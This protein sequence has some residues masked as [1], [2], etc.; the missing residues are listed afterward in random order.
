MYTN[1][2]TITI[3]P[4]YKVILSKPLNDILKQTT[5]T[6]ADISA[7]SITS[8]LVTRMSSEI[9]NSISEFGVSLTM[10]LYTNV[11]FCN[12]PARPVDWDRCL[13]YS[14]MYFLC[15]DPEWCMCLHTSHIQTLSRLSSTRHSLTPWRSTGTP[16]L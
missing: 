10:L 16:S 6:H 14:A 15:S 1:I 12:L 2:K 4:K 9:Y 3:K 5:L 7:F 11:F 13:S 8:K